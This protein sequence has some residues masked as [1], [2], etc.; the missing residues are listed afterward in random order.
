MGVSRSVTAGDPEE[1]AGTEPF[2]I[3]RPGK[4][5]VVEAGSVDIFA[6]PSAPGRLV[7]ARRQV[8]RVREGEGMFGI[9]PPSGFS[10]VLLAVPTPGS[11][12]RMS[13]TSTSASEHAL[14]DSHPMESL[15]ENWIVR[16]SE[17]VI[18]DS[19][20]RHFEFV[21]PGEVA[22]REGVA[23]LPRK[24]VAWVSVLEGRAR[25]AGRVDVPAG[26][27]A[28]FP[29]S[30]SAWLLPAGSARLAVLRAAQVADKPAL[31]SGVNAF[32]AV[33]LECLAGSLEI[34]D[35]R[36]AARI[37][38]RSKA[39]EVRLDR[40]MRLLA[41]PLAEELEAESPVDGSADPWL[42]ACRAIGRRAGIEFRADRRT[43]EAGADPVA[44]IA[45]ASG[46]RVRRV[47]LKGTWWRYDSGP[48]LARRDSGREPV[49]LLP[50]A[51]HGYALFDAAT[52]ETTTVT[53]EIA[54]TLDP[55]AW[56]FYRPFPQ[57]PLAAL[58][59]L[60]FGLQGCRQDLARIVATGAG[61]AIL[62]LFVPVVTGILFDTVIPG[63]DRAQVWQI[64][65]LLLGVSGSTALFHLVQGFALLRMEGRMDASIQAAV[66]DRL[67]SLPVPFFRDYASGDLAMRGLGISRM[68]QIMTGTVLSSFL[69]G[70]FSV[71]GF[72]L[73]FYYSP[74]L[75]LLAVSITLVAVAVTTLVGWQQVRMLREALAVSGR[76][77]GLLLELINGIAKLR[78]SGTEDRAFA[79][80]A[81]SFT[82]QKQL[83]V[84]SR[85]LASA[86]AVF[87]AA[88]PIL[89]ATLVF[90][91]MAKAIAQPGV[92]H[93]TTGE[94]LAF[95]AAFVHF[96]VSTID[97]SVALLSL[98]TV[99]PLYERAKPILRAQPEVTGGKAH[100]GEIAGHIE[101]KHVDFRYRPD[102]PLVL[103]DVTVKIPAGRFVAFVGPS[104]S[105][106]STLLRLLLGFDSPESGAVYF[107]QQDL[108]GL[109]VAA[110]RQQIGV[111]LQSGRLSTGSIY[112]NIVGSA[113]LSME[114]A[115]QAAR[116]A[117][118]EEDIKA[119]PM[120]MHT[121][122]AE[123]GGGLSGGQRQRL[124]IARA[125][126][127][128]PRMILFDE[129]TS[130][131]DNETQS[132]VS[133][134]LESLKAT[135]VVIAHR[136]STVVN[137]DYIYVMDKGVVVQEG[138]YEDLVSRPGPFAELARR[139]MA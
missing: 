92:S 38:R 80:W 43:A 105:G 29:V 59:I 124:M 121:V 111:V 67:L 54:A 93:L 14:P 36:E 86:L 42:R 34:A 123:G 100:P 101:V 76:L 87:S 51:R 95:N 32:H 23:L 16:L 44:T 78:V 18:S 10:A 1:I 66:W 12:V 136:L 132:I 19:P 108:E 89:S 35:R 85:G 97:L 56:Q 128:R 5:W 4:A 61:I 40:A 139:Q 73:L 25:F 60:L 119:M 37:D 63:A 90:Y 114:D 53:A 129:A 72:A 126:V 62:G 118:M 3:D 83:S 7:G 71:V 138:R 6:V 133:R 17:A 107:D 8:L 130:A 13:D 55:F 28:V 31:W 57:K 26:S 9:A 30:S 69:S 20:P 79:S 48:L 113:P 91:V 96:Q 82:R 77:S 50:A 84:R 47:A 70:I 98:L 110:V 135:R 33:A 112:Q 22:A 52:G 94:F 106:K 41:S 103:R 115:V 134:S 24:G 27:D 109:D 99:V 74:S 122:V 21:E 2:R 45:R 104:G 65:V 64:V 117:G 137:A 68:R 46:V 39:D 81:A 120:G 11:R 75:A 102:G 15:L 125:I 116:M 127:K 58:D 88:F 131:L 49:A